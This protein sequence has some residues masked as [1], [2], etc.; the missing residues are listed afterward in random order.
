M[1]IFFLIILAMFLTLPQD[2][3]ASAKNN[4]EKINAYKGDRS[5]FKL[6]SVLEKEKKFTNI[7]NVDNENEEIIE[8]IY[9]K[10]KTNYQY[11]EDNYHYDKFQKYLNDNIEYSNSGRMK[12]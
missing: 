3:F 5:K 4:I 1:K 11:D 9:S 2:A 8:K 10:N 12:Y 7:Q 6:H